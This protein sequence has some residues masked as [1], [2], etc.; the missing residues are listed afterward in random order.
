MA[1]LFW[2]EQSGFKK[3]RLY[4]RYFDAEAGKR[5]WKSLAGSGITEITPDHAK[6]VLREYQHLEKK[7]RA[8]ALL[9][10]VRD[11]LNTP[12]GLFI[13]L[14]EAFV[15]D[16]YHP[17][18]QKKTLAD[19]MTGLK[20]LSEYID[21]LR[22]VKYTG[23][24]KAEH[25]GGYVTFLRKRYSNLVTVETYLRGARAVWRWADLHGPYCRISLTKVMALLKQHEKGISKYVGPNPDDPL[26]PKQNV[27]LLE[28]CLGHTDKNIENK[29]RPYKNA[30]AEE[31]RALR[32]SKGLF[33]F[34]VLLM[35][36]G[37]RRG[38]ALG[39]E[40]S[41]VREEDMALVVKAETSKNRR[42][43][44]VSFKRAPLL[45]EFLRF[46]RRQSNGARYVLQSLDPKRDGNSEMP[47]PQVALAT[48]KKKLE[49]KFRPKLLRMNWVTYNV[50]AP[51]CTGRDA[52]ARLAG[53]STNMAQKHYDQFERLGLQN[54]GATTL[55]EL[56][57][58]SALLED[59]LYEVA[60][61]NLETAH[62]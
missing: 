1:E 59:L 53:H 11:K 54:S 4:V 39:L 44:T 45:A 6:E 32:L 42:Q 2:R 56:M 40:W 23:D 21:G 20:R 16:R 7:G 41:S 25:F 13:G 43:R 61:A 14:R 26:T 17:T 33:P 49:F 38:E 19:A 3:R 27:Q 9:N 8:S 29:R 47:A 37:L 48:L 31:K 62:G 5:K 46:L 34:A 51:W 30:S 60:M 35:L 12:I 50:S 10:G 22:G 15:K 18:R 52:V 58:I 55:E 24:L 36:T 28:A 57:G